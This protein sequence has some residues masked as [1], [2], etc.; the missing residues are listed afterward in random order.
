MLK[1]KDYWLFSLR[2]FS[3]LNPFQVKGLEEAYKDLEKLNK[4]TRGIKVA[5]WI[6]AISTFVLAV[7]AVIALILP[8]LHQ[9]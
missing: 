6:T 2:M 1:V 4:N 9:S 8:L 7:T 5:A 3:Q